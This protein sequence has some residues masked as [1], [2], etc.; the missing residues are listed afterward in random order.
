MKALSFLIKPA[1]SMCNMKCRYCFYQDVSEH[2]CMDCYGRMRDTVREA[3]ITCSLS[4]YEEC[5]IS[6][7]FQGGEPLLAGKNFFQSFV[8]SVEAKKKPG[9]CISYSIQ[10]NGLLLD[11]AWCSFF[12]KYDFL[13]G[14]SI[15]GF[16][17]NHDYFRHTADGH[18]TF[19]SLMEKVRLLKEYVIRY[20]VLTVLSDTLSTH[21]KELL[22]FYIKHEL[23]Y[24]QIIPCLPPLD[25]EKAEHACSPEQFAA[26]YKE[27]YEAWLKELNQKRYI[28]VTLFENLIP[29]YQGIAPEQCGML[30]QCMPQFV[31]EAN[32]DVF[33]CDFYVLDAYKI[34]SVCT[35]SI[36]E[37]VRRSFQSS[38]QAE[39]R[40]FC[41]CCE[42]CRYSG[43]CHKNCKRMNDVL[44]SEDYCGYQDFLSYSEQSMRIIA[45]RLFGSI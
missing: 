23:H 43:M 29:M 3:L 12:K 45:E 13:V 5:R 38:F 30:G 8:D 32:G 2:R 34:G 22:D 18:P 26:F 14:I 9:Q 33:P 25:K 24:V 19:V 10:T 7:C 15:D 39:K 1:S 17:E 37:L 35:D 16:E 21:G 42:K 20:N 28:S 6:Y 40:K 27:F 31:V 44:Y 41:A 36:K 4:A 11:D